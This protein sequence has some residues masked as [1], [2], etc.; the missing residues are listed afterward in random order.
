MRVAMM[1]NVVCLAL[2]CVRGFKNRT[3]PGRH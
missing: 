2:D 3:E 1:G